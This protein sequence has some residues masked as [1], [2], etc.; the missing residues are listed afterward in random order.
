[1]RHITI[2]KTTTKGLCVDLLFKNDSCGSVVVLNQS[3]IRVGPHSFLY[4]DMDCTTYG[5]RVTVNDLKLL[6]VGSMVTNVIYA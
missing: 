2:I 3:H 6:N 5:L 1:M 4:P